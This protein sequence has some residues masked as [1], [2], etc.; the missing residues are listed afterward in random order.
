MRNTTMVT[1]ALSPADR[2]MEATRNRQSFCA[3][4]RRATTA[5]AACRRPVE[6]EALL[7]QTTTSCTSRRRI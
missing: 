6:D 5:A 4:L 2:H 3:P 7:Y 1:R